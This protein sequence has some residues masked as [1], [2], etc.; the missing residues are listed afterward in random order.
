MPKTKETQIEKKEN[1]NK[2]KRVTKKVTDGDLENFFN[3]ENKKIPDI[4]NS[5]EVRHEL[6]HLVQE[7][8]E[9]EIRISE[10]YEI[11]AFEARFP[12]SEKRRK[13]IFDK[14]SHIREEI[15]RKLRF[16][17]ENGLNEI[18]IPEELPFLPKR[19]IKELILNLP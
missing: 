17:I 11:S 10:H 4:K 5:E 1:K 3:E 8:R 19:G 6:Y 2:K 18:E 15:S 13:K 14:R 16:L 7:L 12:N 9:M